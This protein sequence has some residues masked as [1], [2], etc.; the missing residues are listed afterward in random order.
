MR[1]RI[2]PGR[3]SL[4]MSLCLLLGTPIEG[5]QHIPGWVMH[6]TGTLENDVLTCANRSLSN[7]HV[8]TSSTGELVLDVRELEA[9]SLPFEVPVGAVSEQVRA[10]GPRVVLK[11]DD[12][13]LAGFDRG[14]WGGG[15]VWF[16]EGGDSWSNVMDERVIHLAFVRGSVLVTSVT[17]N[18]I[19]HVSRVSK[20][21]PWTITEIASIDGRAHAASIVDAGFLI[22]VT[23]TA[24]VRI[25]A[26]GEVETLASVDLTLLFPNSVVRR[27]N[28][29][30]YIGLRHFVLRLAYRESRYVLEWLVPEDCR[31]FQL[32]PSGWPCRCGPPPIAWQPREKVPGTCFE[33]D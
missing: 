10:Y 32:P 1:T 25:E 7:W 14:E 16:N 33:T 9:G 24:V 29:D 26:P 11:L 8:L 20:Q 15:L 19:S 2:W 18:D 5:S 17:A 12:G 22:V 28:K 31:T 21:A 4:A 30:I 13:W 6:G 3:M 27:P 23:G